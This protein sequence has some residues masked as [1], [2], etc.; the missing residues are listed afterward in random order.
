MRKQILF[1]ATLAIIGLSAAGKTAFITNSSN[2]SVSVIDVANNIVIATIPV[3]SCPARVSVGPD[4][5]KVYL[6]NFYDSS[7]SIINTVSNS[8]SN[9]IPKLK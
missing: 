8:K 2:N 1:I 5:N 4:G 6:A 3:G 7:I 9:I